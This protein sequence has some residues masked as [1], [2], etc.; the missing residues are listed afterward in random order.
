MMGHLQSA[1][2]GI[3]QLLR[4]DYEK[5]DGIEENVQNEIINKIKKL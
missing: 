4:I 1:G 2:K 3:Q 5:I